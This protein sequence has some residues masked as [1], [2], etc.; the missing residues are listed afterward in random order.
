MIGESSK[1]LK[2]LGV[3][4][5]AEK[6]IQLKCIQVAA[7]NGDSPT[8]RLNSFLSYLMKQGLVARI[9]SRRNYQYFLTP[10]GKKLLV[11]MRL[12]REIEALLEEP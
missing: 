9:G 2:I 4:D 7:E 11:K 3:L 8:V 5:S 12:L 1:T 6:P 10:Q